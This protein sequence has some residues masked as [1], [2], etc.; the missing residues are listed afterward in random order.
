MANV[1]K[2]GKI[3]YGRVTHKGKEY[4]DT[5]ETTSRAI[6]QERL[7]EWVEKLRASNWGDKPRRTFKETAEKFMDE[8]LPRLKP[9]S[10]DRYM[11][12]LLHLADHLKGKFLDQITSAVLSE[13]VN[14]RRQDGVTSGS[15]RR[16]LSCLSSIFRCA[17][18]WEYFVGNPPAAYLRAG[19]RRGLKEAPPRTRYMSHEE[20]ALL[21]D[22]VAQR[23]S[24]SVG[25]RDSHAYLMFEAAVIF[26][27]DTGLRKE[28]QLS[29]T[30]KEI[31]L[32]VREVV[33]TDA[34]AKS[35]VGR[36]VPL[37]P[38]TEAILR[39]LP[40]HKANPYV[41][42][43]R[44]GSRYFDLYQQLIRVSTKLGIRDLRWHDLRRT[45]GC[46]LLQDFGLPIERVSLWL[47]HSSSVVTQKV[48]A[49]LDVRHL[50]AAVGTGAR[51]SAQPEARTPDEPI[52]LL[53]D[54]GVEEEEDA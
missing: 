39:A 45:C 51:I 32:D 42:W 20:E 40:R 2:R 38:R 7:A 23:R 46:R 44:D 34:R 43:N 54:Q 37:L 53:A 22:Y 49:F 14:K 21:L 11:H 9:S 24:D 3:W 10:R 17:E 41:F 16:D 27:I 25:N 4:R 31:D 29:V 36:R 26:A 12:S 8:H 5:L 6:A 28:E 15:I 18:E 48:Y 19:K 47:G 13:F 35:G 50:H 30:W 1:Y 52:L 33:V